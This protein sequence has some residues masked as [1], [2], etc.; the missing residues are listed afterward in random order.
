MTAN[1]TMGSPC[2]I[3]CDPGIDDTLAI[4]H[5]MGSDKVDLKAITLTYG[6]TN[7]DNVTK[8]LF[9]ILHV[10]GK[11][12]SPERLATYQGADIERLRR[13]QTLRP[14]VAVGMGALLR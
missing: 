6:N 5:C 12:V 2:I 7:I 3:D 1:T 10:L 11:E 8:N 4:L 14:V 13:I 9:T